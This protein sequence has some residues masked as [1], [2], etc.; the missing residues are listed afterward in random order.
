MIVFV[1]TFIIENMRLISFVS[2]DRP[3]VFVFQ[4]R[5]NASELVCHATGY[6]PRGLMIFWDKDG[7]EVLEDVDIRATLPN[8]DGS[9]QRRAILRVS[10]EDLKKHEYK[11]VVQHSSLLKDLVLPVPSRITTIL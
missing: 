8:Q 3:E 4:K 6:F 9:F 7:E 1:I 2:A 5:S 10:S 11:C